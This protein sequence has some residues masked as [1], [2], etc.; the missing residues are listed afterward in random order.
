MFLAD[1]NSLGVLKF[2]LE[3]LPVNTYL[4]FELNERFLNSN[5]HSRSHLY[6]NKMFSLFS[7]SH[8]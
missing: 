1:K 8:L 5:L 2:T 3:V 6:L 7:C 4:V